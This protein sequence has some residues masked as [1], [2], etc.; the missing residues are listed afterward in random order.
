MFGNKKQ[1]QEIQ[2]IYSDHTEVLNHYRSMIADR[3]ET[4]REYESR[5]KSPDGTKVLHDLQDALNLVREY[6]RAL[7]GAGLADPVIGRA[8]KLLSSWGMQPFSDSNLGFKADKEGEIITTKTGVAPPKDETFEEKIA[9]E[10]AEWGDEAYGKANVEIVAEDL[11]PDPDAPGY[12]RGR[13]KF[14]D[15]GC[16]HDW[17]YEDDPAGEFRTCKLCGAEENGTLK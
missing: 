13:I 6:Q 4:I 16:E 9:R 5:W 2:R 3:D 10:E 17:D 11:G 12:R 1:S 15:L 8:N 14:V 7:H